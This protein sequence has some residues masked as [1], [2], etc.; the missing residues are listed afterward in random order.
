MNQYVHSST[1]NSVSGIMP[2]KRSSPHSSLDVSLEFSVAIETS[3]KRSAK[4][5]EQLA[6]VHMSDQLLVHVLGAANRTVFGYPGFL[7]G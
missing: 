5:L 4:P 6:I 3:I 1:Q 7:D 2:S